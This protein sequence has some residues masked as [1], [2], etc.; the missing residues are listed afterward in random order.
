MK[1]NTYFVSFFFSQKRIMESVYEDAETD[2]RIRFGFFLLVFRE[3]RFSPIYLTIKGSW[4]RKEHE[5]NLISR[6]QIPL[7]KITRL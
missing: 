6:C 7:T 5:I 3:I 2:F 4:K 1:R